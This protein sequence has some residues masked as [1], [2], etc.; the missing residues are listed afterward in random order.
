MNASG[1]LHR[2]RVL[3]GSTLGW[4]QALGERLRGQG[5]EV[6]DVDGRDREQLLAALGDVDIMLCSPQ[7]GF[8]FDAELIAAAPRLRAVNSLVIGLETIDVEACTAAGVLVANGAI[9]ENFLGVAEATVMLILA[10]G[11]DFKAKERAM[12][13]TGSRPL[14]TRA[15]LLRERTV[16]LI[17]IGR[18]GRA[19]VERLRGF[20]VRIQAYDPFVST[21]PAGVALVSLDDLL[22][23]SDI[24]SVHVMLTPQT[25]GLL[26]ARELAMMKPSAYLINTSRGHIVDEAALAAALNDGR[27]AAAAIDTFAQEPTPLDNP[28][29][30]VDPD[31]LILT[32]H[33]IAHSARIPSLLMDAAEENVLREASA[34]VPEY[35]VNTQVIPAWHAR[36]SRLAPART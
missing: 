25:R 35:I 19:V 27:L 22:R 31:K 32:G 11:L 6:L 1:V 26:G 3:F 23:D 7:Q 33:C 29:F 5:C 16:G 14:S 13:A 34:E 8:V 36:L 12:R 4:R 18:I 9:E 30:E 20:N 17:G 15:V 2:P 24:V 10:L 28:L 21:A